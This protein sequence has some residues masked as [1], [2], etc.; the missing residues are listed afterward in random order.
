M[1]SVNPHQTNF[2]PLKGL[3]SPWSAVNATLSSWESSSAEPVRGIAP[4]GI[5]EKSFI[6]SLMVIQCALLHPKFQGST[7]ARL[8]R[9]SLGPLT[10]GWWLSYPFRLPALP[11][12]DRSVFPGIMAAIMI[13]KSLEWTFASGPYH[14]RSLKI[15]QGVPV[16]KKDSTDEL[17]LEKRQSGLGDFALWTVLL[18]TSQRGLRWSWGPESKGNTN[19]FAQALLELVRLQM[20]LLPSLGFVLYSED[21]AN[22]EIDPRGALLRLGVPSFR[23]LGF[24]AGCLHSVGTM[25]A[26]STIVEIP[27]AIAVLLF[28]LVYSIAKTM[29]LSP[30][31]SE[32]VNP[33]GLPPYFGSLFELSSLAHFWGKSWHQKFRRAFLFCGGKPAISLARAL[34]ASPEVQKVCGVFAVF[35]V[36]GLLHEYPLHAFQRE[37]HPYPRELFKTLPGTF[38]FFFAQALGVIL[39]PFVIPHVPKKLG[40]AKLWT[41]SFLLLTAPLFTRDACRPPGLFN[42]FRPLQEWTWVEIL[43]PGPLSS[44]TIATK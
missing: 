12:Q 32:L 8:T 16:W 35:A 15:V 30:K 24:I 40:G 9:L 29:G 18:F 27:S 44:R 7:S 14:I 10:I 34:G 25:T 38:I 36:S 19:S 20:V 28:H 13:F 3:K 37:P 22:Y 31:L 21:W 26:L 6:I 23:G 43:I 4:A 2:F 39:E 41:A 5:F 42:Q 11:I 1:E 33:A 17:S